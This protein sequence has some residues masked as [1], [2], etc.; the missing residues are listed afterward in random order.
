[1]AENIGFNVKV[2]MDVAEIQSE[3]Q[4]AE[5]QLRQFQAQLKKST[6]TIEI[7]M[8]N[9]EIAALNPQIDAYR[10]ALQKVGKPVGDATQ[11]L[12]NFSRIAQDA[13]YGMMGIANNLNPMI[14]SFQRLA[15]TEGGTKKAL[16]AMAQGLMGPAGIGVAV[17]LLSA[18][19]STYSKE[20]GNF[21]K[22]ATGELDD[23]IKKIN[24]LNE[25]LFKITGKSEAKKIKGEVLI[26]II[27]SK[28][29]IQQRQ[30]ALDEL[31]KLYSDSDAIK[32]LTLDSD[33]KALDAA[34]ANASLQYVVIEKEKNNNTK[35]EEALTEKARLTKKRQDEL[36]KITGEKIQGK[37]GRIVTIAEQE[38]PIYKK[39]SEDF[40]K[41][42]ADIAKFKAGAVE[43]NTELSK[44]E[45]VDNK[46][47]KISELDKALKEFNKEILEGENLLKA[48]KLFAKS[49]EDSFA[50]HQLNA[51]DKAIKSI[52][53]ISGPA[54]EEAIGKLL[55]QENAIYDKYYSGKP[56][57]SRAELDTSNI[58]KDT[59]NRTTDKYTGAGLKSLDPAR[60]AREMQM[61]DKEA[62]AIFIKGEIDKEKE[63]SKALKKQQQAYENFA[64]T[65]SNS[66][67]NAFMG[68][69]DAMER[70]Q[71]IGEA[72]GEMFKNLAKQIAASVIQALIFK[73]I[74]AAISGGTSEV[75]GGATGVSSFFNLLVP[76]EF[77]SGGVVNGPTLGLVGEAGPEAIMPL[78][79]LASFLNTSFNAGAMSSGNSSNGGQ[80]ILKGQDLVLALNRSNVSLNL[81]RGI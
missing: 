61:L 60:T 20:I 37:E 19:L 27:G 70:G 76:T 24:T 78:S 44:Y 48:G 35:L 51:I 74:M 36:N 81:R 40:K 54:A 68:L 71:N 52:A 30:T 32:K 16:S 63:V 15:A 9:K 17:G 23:F 66:V 14:E 58:F 65:I 26:G 2:G 38:A 47:N 5:N 13:P 34:L 18:L 53:G 7:N 39:Y 49:G 57:L 56:R 11:S 22:G 46:E 67:T 72:L 4:K 28:A 80:F 3:L 73:A 75:A 31:K 29:D 8:L 50:L 33:K 21:F 42:E 43:L 62:N 77:A 55:Q 1:M 64:G 12:I 6:N 41:V 25:E 45:K 69:F 79:K 10:A 59:S